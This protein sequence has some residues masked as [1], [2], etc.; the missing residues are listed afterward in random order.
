[1]L[2]QISQ[3][4]GKG[5]QGVG[6]SGRLMNR[7]GLALQHLLSIYGHERKEGRASAGVVRRIATSDYWRWVSTPGCAR[8]S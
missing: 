1:M 6:E 8:T 4:L 7:K 3:R 2:T 5:R